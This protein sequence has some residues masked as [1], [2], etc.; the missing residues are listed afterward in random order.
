MSGLPVFYQ[1]PGI[2]GIVNGSYCGPGACVVAIGLTGEEAETRG[3][4]RVCARNT[5]AAAPLWDARVL[6]L[7][8]FSSC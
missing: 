2:L 4:P 5:V 8:V 1:D 7:L 6:P 3:E